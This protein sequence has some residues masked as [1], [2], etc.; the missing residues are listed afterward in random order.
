MIGYLQDIVNSYA[1]FLAFSIVTVDFYWGLFTSQFLHILLSF[2]FDVP[3]S[4]ILLISETYH[5]L[6][7]LKGFMSW[8]YVF[9]ILNSLKKKCH[10][11]Q[12][13]LSFFLWMK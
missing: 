8:N 13:F 5:G 3:F 9:S 4:I 10:N 2:N 12:A 11:A 6:G 1:I 7:K